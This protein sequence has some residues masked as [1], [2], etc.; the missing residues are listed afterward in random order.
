MNQFIDIQQGATQAFVRSG[1]EA[2]DIMV[3]GKHNL[4]VAATGV[5]AHSSRSH[6]IFTITMLTETGKWK[7]I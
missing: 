4:Q 6:C 5:H 1:E 7:K 3:A 2:Y